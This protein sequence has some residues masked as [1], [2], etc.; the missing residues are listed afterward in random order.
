MAVYQEEQKLYPRMLVLIT[1]T[2]DKKRLEDLFA[3]Y[4][5]PVWFQCRGKGTAPS[6]MLD[7]FGLSGTARLITIGIFPKGIVAR[8][9]EQLRDSLRKKGHGI[10]FTLPLTGIQG[11]LL[12]VLNSDAQKAAEATIKERIRNDMTE[13]KERSEYS[14]IWVSVKTG[15][16]D[17]VVEAARTAG[18]KGGTVMKGLRRNSEQV[19]QHFGIPLQDEQEIVIIVVPRTRKKQVMSAICEACGLKTEAHGIILSLPVDEVLGIED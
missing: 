8:I 4:H 1:R 9:F 15:Y 13:T 10:V 5:V 11:G 6:E 19:I 2:E 7:L 14:I 16:S 12:S 3:S 18:A 17:E